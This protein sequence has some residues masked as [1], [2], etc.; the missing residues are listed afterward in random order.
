MANNKILHV[1]S[2]VDGVTEDALDAIVIPGFNAKDYYDQFDV[3]P[4]ADP[5]M[6]DR[7]SV[8]PDDAAFLSKRLHA[9]PAFDFKRFAYFIEAV[10]DD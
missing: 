5:Q 3:D 9:A 2:I 1:L 6:L 8:G 7:Y 10:T 4:N